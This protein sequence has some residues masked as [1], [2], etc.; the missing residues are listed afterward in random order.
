M[1]GE[2]YT[3]QKDSLLFFSYPHNINSRLDYFFMFKSDRHR[4]IKCEIGVKDISD[5]AGVY[6]HLHLDTENKKS[7]WKLNTSLLNDPSCI[8]YIEKEFKEY[9]EH[10]DNDEV[11]TS[12]ICDAAKAVMRGKL[13]MW[14]SI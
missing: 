7:T 11:S 1:F 14:S 8:K 2:K 10:N 9:L 12:Y 6:L 13:I 5:H 3:Q 4:V